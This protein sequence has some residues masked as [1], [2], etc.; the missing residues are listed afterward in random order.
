MTTSPPPHG[1]PDDLWHAIQARA[2]AEGITPGDL[3]HAAL[4]QYLR[5]RQARVSP[6]TA[7]RTPPQPS[8]RQA[9]PAC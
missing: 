3:L 5:R 9:R 2:A 4:T 8:Q 6:K 1:I 7:A